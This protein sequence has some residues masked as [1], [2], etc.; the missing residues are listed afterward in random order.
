MLAREGSHQREGK[1]SIDPGALILFQPSM[2]QVGPGMPPSAL[3]GT[4]DSLARLAALL[5]WC[6][7]TW[8]AAF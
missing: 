3:H 4:G 1:A 5:L 6:N 8:A 2:G 7:R